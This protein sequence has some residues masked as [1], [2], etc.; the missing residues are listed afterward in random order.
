[1]CHTMKLWERMLD[2][3][4]RQKV[5]NAGFMPGR[6]TTELFALGILYWISTGKGK[7]LQCVFFYLKTYDRVSS[8]EFWYCMKNLEATDK[9]VN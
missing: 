3:R 9:Y 4:L 7:E 5:N 1:M 6:S 2:V 8:K